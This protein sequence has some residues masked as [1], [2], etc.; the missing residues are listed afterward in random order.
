MMKLSVVVLSVFSLLLVSKVNWES[1]TEH[2]FGEIPYGKDVS[3]T[4]YFKNISPDSLFIDNV[5][6]S[7]GCTA[8]EWEDSATPP[9]SI[10]AIQIE[11]DGEANTYFRKWIKVYFNGQK[12]AERLYISGE[13]YRE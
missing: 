6:T 8:A 5:R 9:D 13:V 4:F 12:K 11:F 1:P 10:G 7:C 2:D 3:H